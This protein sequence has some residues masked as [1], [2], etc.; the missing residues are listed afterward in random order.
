MPLDRRWKHI[1]D[2]SLAH[3][4]GENQKF[5]AYCFIYNSLWITSKKVQESYCK[6]HIDRNELP[7]RYDF[8]KFRRA[9][10]CPGRYLTCLY[11]VRLPASR[12]LRGF[13]KQASQKKY[14]NE[15][16]EEYVD[17]QGNTGPILCPSISCSLVYDSEQ[18]LQFH[19]QDTYSYPPRNTRTG[20]EQK[21]DIFVGP[22]GDRPIGRKRKRLQVQHQQ[23]TDDS[24]LIG[25]YSRPIERRKRPQVQYQQHIDN[26]KPTG[27]ITS[28]DATISY[29]N[30]LDTSTTMSLPFDVVPS[31]HQESLSVT[32]VSSLSPSLRDTQGHILYAVSSSPAL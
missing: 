19:L 29:I 2:C 32:S 12:R 31:P 14:I 18:D 13:I 21:K 25:G 26:S 11:D 20:D 28:E 3:H 22:G 4:Q 16:F 15:C 9:T 17:N 8:L 27:S 6:G 7:L 24:E 5:I 10:V 23:H 30:S 1:F